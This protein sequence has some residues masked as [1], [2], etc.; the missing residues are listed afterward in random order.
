MGS[1]STALIAYLL[2][3]FVAAQDAPVVLEKG[4]ASGGATAPRP[5]FGDE[6]D[7]SRALFDRLDINRDGYLTGSELTTPE[8]LAA[9]WLGIDRN[10][11]GRIERSEFRA[12]PGGV[13]TTR[14]P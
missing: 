4:S 10:H 6:E 14:Q 2:T 5:S 3:A 12:M 11:D 13:A 1:G 8:A 7:A 9:N